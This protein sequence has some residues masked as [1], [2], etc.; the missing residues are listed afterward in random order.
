MSRAILDP[1]PVAIP[2]NQLLTAFEGDAGHSC[3]KVIGFNS[4]QGGVCQELGVYSGT[5][6][7]WASSL[8]LATSCRAIRAIGFSVRRRS[9]AT[10][11]R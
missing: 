11:A 5:A 1:R 9:R 4:M 2:A 10:R 7:P 3:R 8:G 6:F